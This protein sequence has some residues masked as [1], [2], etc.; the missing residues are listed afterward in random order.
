M[1]MQRGIEHRGLGQKGNGM[2]WVLLIGTLDTKGAEIAF[3]RDRLEGQG[4]NTLVIDVGVQ[5]VPSIHTDMTRDVVAEAAGTTLDAL[6]EANDRGAA[7]KVMTRGATSKVRELFD[8]G[9]VAGVLAVGGSAGTTISCSAMRALPVGV[10]K[11]M[12]STMAS[13]DMAPH[14]GSRDITMMYSVTDF[15]GL[16]RISRRVLG[17]AANAMGGMVTGSATEEVE[18]RPLVGATMFGVTT[19][20]VER[21]RQLLDD[22]GIELIVFHATGAGGRAM[23]DLVRD[24]LLDGVLDITTTELADELVGGVL[25]AGPDRMEIAGQ[26]GLPQVISLGALDMV[27]FGAPETIPARFAGRLFY[28]HNASVTL[29]RTTPEECAELGR[30]IAEKASA[31]TGPVTILLPLDGV[32]AIDRRG[33]VFHNPEADQALFRA[34]RGHCGPNVTLVEVP[35]HINDEAFAQKIAETY[36][37]MMAAHRR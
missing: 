22:A 34:V 9:V 14:V 29:M 15:T 10:P 27:N 19:P 33:Q 5:G 11:L 3:L 36:V 37:E 35:A 7:I 25:S 1:D 16:N 2:Y 4:V 20:C 12:V 26:L 21:V 17:N 28:E 23:E 24:G 8:E 6:L 30:I 32:S 13:G 18:D 31:A